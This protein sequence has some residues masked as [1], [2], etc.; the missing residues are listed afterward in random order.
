[1][2]TAIAVSHLTKVY[3]KSLFRK[4]GVAALQGLSLSVDRGQIYGFLGPNGAGKTTLIK[5]LLSL[6][7]PTSGDAAL[8][9]QELPDTAVRE[10][11]GYLPENQ[12]FPGYLTGEQ[13]LK[14]F[15][16]LSGTPP[17]LLRRR[18]SEL[19]TLVG[20]DQ[21]RRM[22]VKRYSK[23]ML[24]RIGLAQALVN[25][26]ELIFLD[27]PT[28][29]VD[30][31]GRK[32]IRDILHALKVQGKTIFLNSHLLS[33]V[34]LVCDRVAIVNK[35][36]LLKEGTIADF[37]SGSTTYIVGVEGTLPQPLMDEARALVIS[38]S[39][40]PGGVTINAPKTADLNRG[41][42]LLRRHNVTITSIQ[43]D[44]ATLEESFLDLLKR[45][46]AP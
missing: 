17:D 6:V 26:P 4:N 40:H 43:R 25:D 19:L 5:I 42:D 41:I 23:G 30:P 12:R 1:M 24:Q 14:F 22:K 21:W 45:E 31:I 13:V 27:E 20:M 7:H 11:I 9:G 28:D 8:L 37:T 46:V 32:E 35:G 38:L 44:K 2:S 16:R 34:E 36:S 15:G 10:K 3:R 33:E 18:T 29:G 39:P